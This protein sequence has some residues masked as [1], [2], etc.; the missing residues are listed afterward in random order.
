[1]YM[2][3]LIQENQQEPHLKVIKNSKGKIKNTVKR[4]YINTLTPGFNFRNSNGE[5]ITPQSYNLL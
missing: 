3:P 1:M 2:K 5:V 4:L